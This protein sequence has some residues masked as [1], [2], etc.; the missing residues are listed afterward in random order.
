MRTSMLKI[1]CHFNIW[2]YLYP[3]FSMTGS[4]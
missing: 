2:S 4:G 1:L 3:F